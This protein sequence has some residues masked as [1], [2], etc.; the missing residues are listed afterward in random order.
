MY[1]VS[2]R[3]ID[4]FLSI[5]LLIIFSPI[6]FCIFILILLIDKQF[7]ILFKR[8]LES[9]R[10]FFNFYKFKTMKKILLLDLVLF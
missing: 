8:E 6:L 1:R 5:S 10:K 9:I 7:P 4:I 2:K 3:L